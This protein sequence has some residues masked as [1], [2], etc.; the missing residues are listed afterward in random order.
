MRPP[1]RK[2]PNGA[3]RRPPQQRTSSPANRTASRLLAWQVMIDGP[4]G[5]LRWSR[6][7]DEASARAAVHRL[8]RHGF[9]AWAEGSR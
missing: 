9:D 2:G 8:V 1:E 4:R 5:P 6:Y 3:D 7:V